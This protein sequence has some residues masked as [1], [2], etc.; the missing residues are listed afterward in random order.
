MFTKIIPINDTIIETKVTELYNQGNE[1]QIP[2]VRLCKDM[3]IELFLSHMLGN[4]LTILEMYFEQGKP[5]DFE[6]YARK[7]L[8]VLHDACNVVIEIQLAEDIPQSYN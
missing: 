7:A 8:K 3:G 6:I 2:T 5:A 4:E 1:F